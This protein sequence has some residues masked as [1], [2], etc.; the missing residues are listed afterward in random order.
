MTCFSLVKIDEDRL[1]ALLDEHVR[2]C[3]RAR[4][5]AVPEREW[6]LRLLG[7]QRE[8]RMPRRRRWWTALLLYTE[9]TC[10][11]ARREGR[12]DGLW[13]RRRRRP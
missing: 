8:R 10:G 3:W 13:R 6:A 12:D 4:A 5:L 11:L 1:Q 9:H 2:V 7:A